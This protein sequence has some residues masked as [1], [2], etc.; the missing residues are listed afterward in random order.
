MADVG[1]GAADTVAVICIAS[2]VG[3]AAGLALVTTPIWAPVLFMARVEERS[4]QR[5]VWSDR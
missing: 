2:M 5:K 3:G 1:G 4:F